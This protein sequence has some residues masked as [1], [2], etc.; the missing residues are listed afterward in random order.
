MVYGKKRGICL[1]EPN[2]TLSK[3]YLQRAHKDLLASKNMKDISWKV[4][5]LYY[6]AYNMFYSLLMRIGI[7]SEIHDCT[8]SLIDYLAFWDLFD[9]ENYLLLKALKKKRIN[10]QYYLKEEELS[11]EKIEKIEEF[12]LRCETIIKTTNTSTIHDIRKSIKNL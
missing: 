6:S 9:T 12:I 8:I 11:N 3:S 2:E 1:I 5:S 4:V 7:K 10:T